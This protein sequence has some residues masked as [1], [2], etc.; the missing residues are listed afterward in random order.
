M[1]GKE[2]PLIVDVK[3][4]S[5]RKFSALKEVLNPRVVIDINDGSQHSEIFAGVRYAL[6]WKP[7]AGLFSRLPDLEI[8]FSVGAGVDHIFDCGEIP[9]VPIVRF[10]DQSLTTRMSEWI[11]HQCLNHLRQQRTYDRQQKNR[12]WHEL[13]QPE[14]NDITVGIMGMGELG[15]DAA[16]K[17]S[18]L[19][20]N[21]LG[22]SRTRKHLPGI[23]CFEESEISLFLS[24]S[25]FLVGLLPLT[26]QTRGIFNRELFSCLARHEEIPSPVFINAGRGGSHN[27]SDLIACLEDDT[28]GGVSLDVFET[29]PLPTDSPLW[30]HENAILTPHVAAVS[31]I[32]ALARH[33]ADQ[34]NRHE[35]G[36]ALEHVVDRS[37]G[38]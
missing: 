28:L 14:A 9:D 17:L 24:R 37:A 2:S 23:E 10:V 8:I 34:I 15:T 6:V 38:Y 13:A 22:W 3:F 20:F 35:N 32:E 26:D 16:K 30:E 21:V 33:V 36:K 1:H 4:D 31:D 11:C 19:G 7:D 5:V 27:E 12:N 29:E 25:N 18:I